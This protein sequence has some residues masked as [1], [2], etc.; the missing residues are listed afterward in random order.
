MLIHFYL[1]LFLTSYTLTTA[2]IA[3]YNSNQKT[4]DEV[5]HLVTVLHISLLFLFTEIFSVKRSR[6]ETNFVNECQDCQLKY[7][8]CDIN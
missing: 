6:F 5:R 3:L 4:F 2:K 7:Y 8:V 1:Y